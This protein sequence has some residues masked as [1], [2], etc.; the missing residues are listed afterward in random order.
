MFHILLFSKLA[1]FVRYIFFLLKSHFNPNGDLTICIITFIV[2][3]SYSSLCCYCY[4]FYLFKC[5]FSQFICTP[6]IIM[7][8]LESAWYPILT[9][10]F[11]VTWA[12]KLHINRMHFVIYKYVYIYIYIYIGREWETMIWDHILIKQSTK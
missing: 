12:C 6:K 9:F 7:V 1:R 10:Y 4:L 8:I 3:F 2:H 11:H 5:I